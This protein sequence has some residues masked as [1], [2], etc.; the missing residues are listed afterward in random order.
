VA[1]NGRSD[2]LADGAAA[3][4]LDRDWLLG[5]LL[6][7]VGIPTLH[8]HVGLVPYPESSLEIPSSDGSHVRRSSLSRDLVEQG[9]DR[10]RK[11]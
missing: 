11:S 8:V 3:R 4:E 9:S 2:G 10:I 7:H 1:S 6:A 5:F